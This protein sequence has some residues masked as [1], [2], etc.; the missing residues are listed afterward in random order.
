M[1]LSIPNY[2]K[3]AALQDVSLRYEW[4]DWRT[5]PVLDTPDEELVARLEKLSQR[6]V[7]AFECATAEWIVYRF[8]KLND[9]SAPWQ[10]LEAAW[11]MI[12]HRRYCGYGSSGWQYY[13]QKGWDGPVRRPIKNALDGLEIDFQQLFSEFH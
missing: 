13:A 11:A 3:T 6:A 4:D 1:T 12:V 7:L 8:D 5:L 2:L 9:N 10:Y